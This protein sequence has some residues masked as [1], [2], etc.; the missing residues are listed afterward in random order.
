MQAIEAQ[1]VKFKMT[2]NH[3]HVIFKIDNLP[4]QEIGNIRGDVESGKL[5]LEPFIKCNETDQWI[6]AGWTR[7]CHALAAVSDNPKNLDTVK[8]DGEPGR[9][10]QYPFKQPEPGQ[11]HLEWHEEASKPW[12]ESIR[13]L[14]RYH[15]ADPMAY[16]D[17]YPQNSS[18]APITAKAVNTHCLN[19]ASNASV[20]CGKPR[21]RSARPCE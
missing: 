17:K 3:S 9:G 14:M 15:A 7:P 21:T 2:L 18:P 20:G 1:G 16:S 11:Y 5:V 6:G 19:K 10:I 12:K 13:S 8:D 4:E